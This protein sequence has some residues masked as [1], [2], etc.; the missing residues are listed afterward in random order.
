LFDGIAILS[1][2]LHTRKSGF[3]KNTEAGIN[4]VLREVLFHSRQVIE[5]SI[6]LDF[7]M[8][9]TEP[10]PLEA[11]V[12][13]FGRVNRQGQKGVVLV[14]V[15]THSI[16]D[17]MVYDA[18]LVSR[19]ISILKHYEDS[20]IDEWKITE[21]L[22]K[23][24]EGMEE[25]F[26][27]EAERSR[28]EF[29]TACIGT[30]RAFESSP[31][32]ADRFDDLFDNTEVLAKCLENEFARL[33]EQSVIE[34]HG[35]LLLQITEILGWHFTLRSVCITSNG[36]I[37]QGEPQRC[38]FRIGNTVGRSH[39]SLRFHAYFGIPITC[40]HEIWLLFI[41]LLCSLIVNITIK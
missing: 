32:L 15:L 27:R 39:G 35:L 4:L 20:P 7:D 11:L 25:G 5:V 28:R 34:A 26:I 29:K 36:H 24:Y 16:D 10:A 19:A 12:Q 1:L 3:T 41:V 9:I 8:I 18:R 2:T 37:N 6:N 17:G 23:V 30:L 22:N 31:A 38:R 33:Y 21:W 40:F 14:R 13:R